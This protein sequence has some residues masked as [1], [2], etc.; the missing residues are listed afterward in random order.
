MNHFVILASIGSDLLETGKNTAKQFGVDWPHLVSQIISFCI[1]AALLY[2]F[3]YK[4]ILQVLEERRLRIADG[5]A[6]ADKIKAE[7]A[8]TEAARLEVLNQANAQ[9]NKLIE[10]ARAAAA[11]VQEQETQKA[12]AAAEQIIVKAREAAAQ[13]HERMLAEL[14]RE[15]GRLV[16]DTTSK[17]TGKVLTPDD[18][19]RLADE[20]SRQL[21]A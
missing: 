19:K 18:Q 20:T 11:R 13:D 16:V 5:L 12:I 8:R 6:N 15:V 17:V 4:R 2:F 9:A 14:R 7:L 21:A 10:E 1:V 3:A